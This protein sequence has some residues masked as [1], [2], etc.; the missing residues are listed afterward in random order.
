MFAGA[1]MGHPSSD[2]GLVLRSHHGDAVHQ[3]CY[4][5]WFRN[6]RLQL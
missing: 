1:N 5:T 4:P 2:E 3:G 6:A